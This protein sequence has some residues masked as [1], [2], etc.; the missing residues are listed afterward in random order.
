LNF[1]KMK[2][3]FGKYKIKEFKYWEVYLHKNQ[4]YLGRVYIW[5]KRDEAVDLMEMTPEERRELFN[6]GRSVNRALAEL[7]SPDLMNYAALGNI[8]THLH[9]HVIPRYSASRS[10]DG[11]DFIDG[12]WGRNYAP[13][14]YDFKVSEDTLTKIR[15]VIIEKLGA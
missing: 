13:Y 9:L 3:T 1:M 2:E 12:R 15:D 11:V 10:F 5:A 14:D 7:F 6:I 8:S 4:Y